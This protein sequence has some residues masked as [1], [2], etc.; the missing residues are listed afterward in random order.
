VTSVSESVSG[1]LGS[2]REAADRASDSVITPAAGCLRCGRP[3]PAQRRGRGG[4]FCCGRCRSAAY[5]DRQRDLVAELRQIVARASVILRELTGDE[6]DR[7]TALPDES[8]DADGQVRKS[9]RQAPN[10][11]VGQSTD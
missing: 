10:G 8:L 4:K 9:A 1:E 3:L 7:S 5:Q 2:P 11:T 6:T